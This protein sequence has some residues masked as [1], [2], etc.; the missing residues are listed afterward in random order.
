[1]RL[2]L[3]TRA[4]LWWLADD[5]KLSDRAREVVSSLSSVVHV[6]AASLW[7]IALKEALGRLEVDAGD[8]SEEIEA[9]GFV[10]LPV[11]ARHGWLAGRLPKLHADPFVRLLVAQASAENLTL[12]SSD[13]KLEGYDIALL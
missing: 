12:V 4:Y 5:P 8:L 10:E 13:R 6:S 11:S 2:L 7:E 9:N 1:M 3:D